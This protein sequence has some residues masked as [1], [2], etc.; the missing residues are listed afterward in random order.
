MWIELKEFHS[1]EMS[2]FNTE[3]FRR[4]QKTVSPDESKRPIVCITFKDG[5]E[6]LFDADYDSVISKLNG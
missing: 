4:V 3:D 5:G 6:I 2:T 1:K